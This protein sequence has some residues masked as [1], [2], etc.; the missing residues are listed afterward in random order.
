M[1]PFN[2]FLFLTGIET[3][4][5][6]MDAHSRNALAVAR[7]LERSPYVSWVK[8]PR[9]ESSSYFELSKK[10]MPLGCGSIL[11]FGVKGGLEAGRRFIDSVQ[12]LSHLANIGDAKSLV[13]HPASTTH[14]QLSDE[15]QLAAG[16]TKDLVRLSAGIEDVEDIIWDLDQALEA[17]QAA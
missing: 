13:I 12:L 3:L 11:T 5:L 9:L 15:Q 6:R 1:S 17:S 16:I 14:Q 8:Y 7:H 4:K 2:S 10:Y